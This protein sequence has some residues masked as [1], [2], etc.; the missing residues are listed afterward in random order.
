MGNFMTPD[1]L[2]K[3]YSGY[4]VIA[5]IFRML[6]GAV[7]SY[8]L[9]I[10]SIQ[11]AMVVVGILFSVITVLFSIYMKSRIGLKPEEYTK[12]DVVCIG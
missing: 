12:K 1:M 5:S 6:A 10:M 4:S 9:T 3:I 11:Y 2:T 7:G 8:L